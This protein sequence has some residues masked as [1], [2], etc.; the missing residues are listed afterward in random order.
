MGSIF[1]SKKVLNGIGRDVQP[2]TCIYD[3]P[4]RIEIRSVPETLFLNIKQKKKDRMKKSIEQEC[5][6]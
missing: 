1:S 4:R 2:Y 6:H 3:D 5:I